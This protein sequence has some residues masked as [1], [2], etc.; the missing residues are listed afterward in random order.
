MLIDELVS[1]GVM[2]YLARVLL[3][4]GFGVAVSTV[5]LIGTIGVSDARGQASV[6]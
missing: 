3:A 6:G 2:Y 4:V 1:R 5:L